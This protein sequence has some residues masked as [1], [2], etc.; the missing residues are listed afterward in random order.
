MD[1]SNLFEA[2]AA[3]LSS[4]LVGRMRFSACGTSA[5]GRLPPSLCLADKHD[6]VLPIFISHVLDVD[7]STDR[8]VRFEHGLGRTRPQPLDQDWSNP[9]GRHIALNEDVVAVLP[10]RARIGLD[11]V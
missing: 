7:Q 8:L 11:Q 3:K 1:P 9:D 10:H 5:K 6:K 4:E 2:G